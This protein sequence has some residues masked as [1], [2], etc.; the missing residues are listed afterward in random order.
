M[1]YQLMA[2]T[3]QTV[4][5]DSSGKS[6]GKAG[7]A[8]SVRQPLRAVQ[9]R[10]ASE[11]K[12]PAKGDFDAAK[13]DGGPKSVSAADESSK[14]GDLDLSA[15]NDPQL[16]A[17][18]NEIIEEICAVAASGGLAT[19]E[20]V[21]EFLMGLYGAKANA[22]VIA[23]LRDAL[24]D[25]ITTKML[26]TKVSAVKGAVTQWSIKY[27]IDNLVLSDLHIPRE[28]FSLSSPH[29]DLLQFKFTGI[30]CVCVSLALR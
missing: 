24:V 25:W 30:R 1:L 19:N 26:S 23:A 20:L 10:A 17:R 12:Q 4:Y 16:S 6:K 3:V 28:G 13:K 18:G 27:H 7:G 8:E 5:D 2:P 29:P 11:N 14:V 15:F 21:V 22:P 9:S